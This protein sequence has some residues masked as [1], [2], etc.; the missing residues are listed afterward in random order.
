MAFIRRRRF[1]PAI[2]EEFG[3][4]NSNIVVE[5]AHGREPIRRWVKGWKDADGRVATISG[6]LYEPLMA[7]VQAALEGKPL[8]PVNFLWMQGERDARKGHGDVYEASLRSLLDQVATDLERHDLN[9]VL[10]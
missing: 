2:A 6:D 3:E 8:A 9:C 10:G 1:T 4:D 5:D 7:K